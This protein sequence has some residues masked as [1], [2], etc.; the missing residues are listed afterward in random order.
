[1]GGAAMRLLASRL[2]LLACAL[3]AVVPATAGAASPPKVT[4]V[5]PLHLKI[6]ER[7]TVKGSG[8]LA[9]KNRNTV[10]FKATGHPA[11]FAKALSATK[12]KLVVKVPTK[13]VPYLKVKAGQPV[14]TRF[15]LRVL[16]QRL[17]K[18]YTPVGASPT[19][20]PAVT[21]A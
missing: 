19:I 13:L 7:L 14:A 12:T 8:F 21:A 9:G 6:G 17:S 15:Q 3:L 2:L 1:M 5:A 11:V 16:A 18:A 20:G 4:S 10:V